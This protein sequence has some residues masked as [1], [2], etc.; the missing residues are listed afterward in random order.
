M[1]KATEKPGMFCLLLFQDRYV[2]SWGDQ[3]WFWQWIVGWFANKS[4]Q[5]W[6]GEGPAGVFGCLC[7]VCCWSSNRDLCTAA[8]QEGSWA[9]WG[10]KEKWDL[11]DHSFLIHML[12]PLAL[13]QVQRIYLFTPY[14]CAHHRVV[15]EVCVPSH[16]IYDGKYNAN[17]FTIKLRGIILKCYIVRNPK[18]KNWTYEYQWSLLQNGFLYIHLSWNSIYNAILVLSSLIIIVY[19]NHSH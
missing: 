8:L 4:K 15:C 3:S 6:N 16:F 9:E 19:Y 18:R 10:C 13:N 1:R 14:P 17:L 5:R 2:E 11:S 12:S 7:A